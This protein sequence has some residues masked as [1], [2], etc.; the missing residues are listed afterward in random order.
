MDFNGLVRHYYLRQGANVADVRF[1][2]VAKKRRAQQSHAIALRLRN[3]LQAIAA[4]HGANI[5]IVES[6][7]G[8]P[9]IS[10][11]VAE[12]YG[13]AGSPTASWPPAAR[14]VRRLMEDTPNVVDVDDVLVAPQTQA[15]VRRR[16]GQGGPE[17]HQRLPRSPQLLDGAVQGSKPALAAPG[18]PGQSRV[19]SSLRCRATSAARSSRLGQFTVRSTGGEAVPLAELGRFEETTIDQPI[20]H[21]N[22]RPVVYVFG[23][24]AGLPPPVAVFTAGATR[25]S[26]SPP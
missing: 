1:N 7:P 22:L 9:V 20:Y 2:L 24:T 6:P 3:D 18:R 19:G 15:A 25:S 10:T 5:K 17:R 26:T 4:Q 23:D 13:S 21:K 14:Q 16:S 12:V 8:P 11:L